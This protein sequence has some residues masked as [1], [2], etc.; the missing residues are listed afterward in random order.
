MK[1]RD[2]NVGG[3]FTVSGTN[4]DTINKEIQ[5][6]LAMLSA[7]MEDAQYCTTVCGE[8]V[9][10]HV[11]IM[12]KPCTNKDGMI[13]TPVNGCTT[14][15]LDHALKTALWLSSYTRNTYC[16]KT[17]LLY[18]DGVETYEYYAYAANIERNTVLTVDVV[19][20]RN[21]EDKYYGITLDEYINWIKDCRAD[22]VMYEVVSYKE[23]GL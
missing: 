4:D 7:D 21:P 14:E 6:R 5:L 18:N 3:F 20:P 15:R 9:T 13:T 19:N 16:V 22:A 23:I 8:I 17:K 1:F 12:Y 11:L 2:T 10:H